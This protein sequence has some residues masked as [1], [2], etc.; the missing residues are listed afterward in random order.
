MERIPNLTSLRANLDGYDSR[1]TIDDEHPLFN[2]PLVDPREPDF[3]FN[4]ATSFY[5]KP[6]HIIGEIPPGIPD[7]PLIRLDVVKRLVRAEK[8]LRTNPGVRDSLG[9]PAHIRIDDAL[10]AYQIQM[11][12]FEI[13]WPAVIRKLNP[14]LSDL[15]VAA[16]VP[17]YCDKPL[18]YLSP[19]PHSTGSA[20]DVALVNLETG[21]EFDLGSPKGDAKET[22]YPDY[23]EG[24]QQIPGQSDINNSPDQPKQLS[25]KR[26]IILARRVLYFAMTEIAGLNV[27]TIKIRHYG[28]GDPLSEYVSGSNHPYYG[29]ADLPQWYL[30]KLSEMTDE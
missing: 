3:G 15:K 13:A 30:D 8:Y 20:V 12:A 27:S 10:R 2:D 5:S 23:Y 7:I 6:N 9:A 25:G 29:I 4:D 19:T 1:Y 17:E 16:Q 26:E 14:S 21:V 18:K 28:K 22:A 11:F 24:Y